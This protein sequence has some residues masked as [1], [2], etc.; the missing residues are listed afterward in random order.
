MDKDGRVVKFADPEIYVRTSRN[1]ALLG[2]ENGSTDPADNYK[3]R[4]QR[5]RNGKLLLYVQAK[6][7]IEEAEVTISS[8]LYG[9]V[10]VTFD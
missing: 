4:V 7:H 3:D 10:A 2:T 5:C 8:P 9:E 1:L 6:E